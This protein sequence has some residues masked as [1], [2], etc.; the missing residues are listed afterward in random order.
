MATDQAPRFRVTRIGAGHEGDLAAEL[1]AADAA[2]YELPNGGVI[3]LGNGDLLVI[4]SLSRASR[5]D[6]AATYPS[7]LTSSP[8]GLER[9]VARS[10]RRAVFVQV[11]VDRRVPGKADRRTS[12]PLASRSAVGSV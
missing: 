12:L 10:P 8:T 7:P 1:E 11:T 4:S 6:R 3:P 2:G 9:R 5:G